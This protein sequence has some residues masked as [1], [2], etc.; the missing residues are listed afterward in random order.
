MTC[1]SGTPICTSQEAQVWRR[2]CG[3]K[4]PIPA[5]LQA[6]AKLNLTDLTGS[7]FLLQNTQGEDGQ[8]SARKRVRD[9][10]AALACYVS[11]VETGKKNP[12]DFMVR[13]I[14]AHYSLTPDQ[15]D[16]LEQAEESR[17]EVIIS[18]EGLTELQRKV[19]AAFGRR[20]SYLTNDEL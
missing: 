17:S 5:R 7:P 10:I 1:T 16:E 13:E 3:V 18:M 11:A 15:S 14:A 12:T 20:F 19:A 4:Y 6:L 9:R 8:C 2:S